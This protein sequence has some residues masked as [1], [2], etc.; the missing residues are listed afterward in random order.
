MN[1]IVADLHIHSNYSDGNLSVEDICK[2]LKIKGIKYFSI[3]D[4]D[5]NR[6]FYDAELN[7]KRYELEYFPGIEFS[8]VHKKRQVHILFYGKKMTEIGKELELRKNDRFS[9]ILKMVELLKGFN[10]HI[11]KED[12][13]FEAKYSESIGRPHLARVMVKRGFV[14]NLKE[15]FEKYIGDD[16]PCYVPKKEFTVKET[17]D[18]I[19]NYKGLAVLA[20]PYENNIVEFID[21]IIGYDIDGIEVFSPKNNQF[22]IDF[23]REKAFK[24]SLLIT[25]GTDFHG[26]GEYQKYG[27]NSL[28]FEEFYNVWRNL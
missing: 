23:L 14:S 2:L 25:G 11:E 1:N 5:S 3:T 8:T 26:D 13:F 20:H 18:M 15:A 21:E 17:V 19:H 24:N 4:H 10:I 12:L 7:S 16:K 27:L 6:S 9:R 22:N 28:N